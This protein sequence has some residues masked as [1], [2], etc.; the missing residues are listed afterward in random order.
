MGGVKWLEKSERL[1]SFFNKSSKLS[2]MRENLFDYHKAAASSL[3]F[4]SSSPSQK[5]FMVYIG[6]GTVITLSV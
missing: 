5:C 6:I 2:E 4:K 1:R 3:C